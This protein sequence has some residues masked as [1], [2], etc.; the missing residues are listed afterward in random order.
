M[1][2][3]YLLD[4]F[5]V[6]SETFIVREIEALKRRGVSITVFAVARRSAD[7]IHEDSI[8]LLED[9]RFIGELRRS[10]SK[11]S[12]IPL[13]LKFF[14]RKPVQYLIALS[15]AV[16]G[17]RKV[18]QCFFWSPFYADLMSREGVQQLHAH[19]VLDGCMH[20]MFISLLM[21][22]PY[23]V[24]VHAHDIFHPKYEELRKEKLGYAS[25]IAAISRFNKTF[26]ETR[27]P[28]IAAG[29]IQIVRCGIDL[30]EF[31]VASGR[32]S[33][34]R[35]VLAVGRLVE[36][37]GFSYLI[38]ACA[39]LRERGVDNFSVDIIGE[40]VERNSLEAKILDLGLQSRVNLLGQR[41]QAFVRG[42]LD[43]AD[44]FVLPCVQEAS[45]M[46]DGIP[47]ALMEAMAKAIPVI[48]TGVSGIPE[49]IVDGGYV[50]DSQNSVALADAM[51]KVL[52]M[53]PAQRNALGRRGREIIAR[54]FNIDR[55]AEKL[56]ALMSPRVT[57][58]DS[59]LPRIQ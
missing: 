37:K 34:M 52:A 2:V 57:C 25:F 43:A 21:G 16:G 51:Q 53:A 15:K 9:V 46:M 10:R 22:I 55:E 30:D 44:V 41:D 14:L 40:G 50:V 59:T 18:L 31:E 32:R 35:S 13:H 24:T 12:L 49:L 56:V 39:L 27:Y 4:V 11:G 38:E 1:R 33:T 3:A 58:S 45:G 19:F 26:V 42:A 6:L 54:E 8:A 36:Q 5:P 48:S 29:K 20:A 23:S 17:S 7:V 28:T 47:V